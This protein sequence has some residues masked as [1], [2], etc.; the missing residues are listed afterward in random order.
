MIAHR[1]IIHFLAEYQLE[2]FLIL[3]VLELRL[4]ADQ[5]TVLQEVV[6]SDGAGVQPLRLIVVRPCTTAVSCHS[7]PLCKTYSLSER[8]TWKHMTSPSWISLCA[9]VIFGFMI[10]I[11]PGFISYGASLGSNPEEEN[12]N[13]L[14]RG[15]EEW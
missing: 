12:E 1:L 5:D 14:R 2:F 7:K 9:N 8:S 4:E 15:E 11:I 10:S 3:R 6:I 13:A